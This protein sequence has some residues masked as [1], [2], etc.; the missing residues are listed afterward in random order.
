[1][2]LKD[3]FYDFFLLFIAHC[4]NGQELLPSDDYRDGYIPICPETTGERQPLNGCRKFK[5]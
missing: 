2:K 4:I 1:M 5:C 3:F